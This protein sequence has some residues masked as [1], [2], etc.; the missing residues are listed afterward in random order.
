MSEEVGS[1][2]GR[3]VT[4]LRQR[5]YILVRSLGQG[6]CGQTVLLHD[7]QIDKYFVCKK[8]SPFSESR[9][10][11]LYDN[12]T[13]EIKLLH[14]VHHPNVVRIFNSYLYPDQCV[15]YLLMEFVD[16]MEIDNYASLRPENI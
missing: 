7:D 10:S 3:L 15:G 1:I 13:R 12:F 6:A 2:E 4:F 8:Y 14:L 16:G 9:R 11:E 5:D